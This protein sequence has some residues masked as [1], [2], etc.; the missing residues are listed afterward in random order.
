MVALH[1]WLFNN[2][3]NNMARNLSQNGYGGSGLSWR[4]Y[5]YDGKY[6]D[7]DSTVMMMTVSTTM[8]TMMIVV[9]LCA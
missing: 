8:T 7:D 9:L 2:D 4:C 3:L 6:D 5:K 1:S